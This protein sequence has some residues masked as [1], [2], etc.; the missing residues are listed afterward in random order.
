MCAV[1]GA[2]NC[3]SL[4]LGLDLVSDLLLQVQTVPLVGLEGLVEEALIFL[5]FYGSFLGESLDALEDIHTHAAGNEESFDLF[6]GFGG[7][8]TENLIRRDVH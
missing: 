1:V 2:E 6:L 8:V 4:L 3:H 7:G 5:L